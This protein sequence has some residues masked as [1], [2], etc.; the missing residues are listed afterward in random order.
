MFCREACTL[1]GSHCV[2]MAAAREERIALV[3]R[4]S[5]FMCSRTRWRC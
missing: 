2:F 5:W 4:K 1:T 3:I